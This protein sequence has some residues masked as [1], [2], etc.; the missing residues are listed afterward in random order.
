MSMTELAINLIRTDGGTQPRAELDYGVIQDYAQQMWEGAVFPDVI[1]FYDGVDYWLGDG[2]HRYHATTRICRETINAEVRQGT[3]RDAQLYSVGANAT[4]GLRRTNAD[5]RRAVETLLRD[6][7]WGKWSNREIARKCG[8]DEGTVRNIRSSFTAEFPQLERA[9][10]TRH[11]TVATMNTV[12]IG[13][14]R[15]LQQEQSILL[16]PAEVQALEPQPGPLYGTVY[17]SP[18]PAY[19]PPTHYAPPSL[20]VIPTY[21]ADED[22]DDEEEEYEETEEDR[23]ETAVA[24]GTLDYYYADLRREA[25]QRDEEEREKRRGVPAALQTSDS[26][27]WYTPGQYVEAARTLMGSIDIDPASNA[28]AN[29]TIQATTYYDIETNG[30]DKDWAGRVWLNP[31]YGREGGDSNQEIW[32]HRLI[33][34]FQSGITTEAVL[35]VNANTEAKWFQPLYDYLICFTNHRIRFYNTEG[36]SSQPTQGNALIY[37]GP[38][39]ARFTELFKQFG[40]I[41]RRIA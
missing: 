31:P 19:T 14:S 13:Q 24:T 34:Q 33:E 39:K 3:R 16:T 23:F 12:N 29:E 26:N 21:P 9:Y 8:V 2:F 28:L 15:E 22:T 32:S 10:V 7:E 36:S 38:Q 5:K 1:V 41:V 30:L 6:P 25:M 37:F 27:E 17:Q 40:P 4:H 35:L 18:A 20:S 11:G